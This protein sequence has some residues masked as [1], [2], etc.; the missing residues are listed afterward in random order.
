M[1]PLRYRKLLVPLDCSPLAALA[2]PAAGALAR[3]AGATVHLVSVQ[4]GVPKYPRIPPEIA[5]T[6]EREARERLDS[7][8]A[9]EATA[10][11]TCHGLETACAVIDGSPPEALGE[12]AQRNGVDLIVMTTHGRGGLG[13][14]WLGSVA[15]RLLRC[16]RTP[17]L[18]LR[19]REHPQHT[20]LRHVLVAL[21][22]STAGEAVLEGALA[23]A[24]L[25]H[26]ARC[27]LV[28][29]IEA[30]LA[31]SGD[32]AVYPDQVYGH[33]LEEQQALARANLERLAERPRSLGIATNVY[34]PIAASAGTHI[35]E[36]AYKL[37]S[38]LIVLGTHGREGL[39]R[40]LLG[41][42][43]DK[44]IRGA[45]TPVLVVPV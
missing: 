5:K 41:S 15:D 26:E 45:A 42:V 32:L 39:P 23:M 14:F 3:R 1:A 40:L 25:Y 21:D 28:Q 12:Y 29:V 10:L 19:S 24:S 16:T 38:D 27:S 6:I 13:R 18:L 30:P 34:T 35:V 11:S 4:L 8:L 43:A 17:V 20:D 2:I 36:L 7:Y 44:V 9:G 33:V 22:G 37:D 31:I